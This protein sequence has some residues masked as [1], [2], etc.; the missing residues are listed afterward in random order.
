M[1]D[2]PKK[3]YLTENDI[4][5]NDNKIYNYYIALITSNDNEEIIKKK[6]Q[7]LDRFFKLQDV[8][9]ISKF[10]FKQPEE[11]IEYIE[12]TPLTVGDKIGYC[13]IAN[14][15]TFNNIDLL[16]SMSDMFLQIKE[17]V[18]EQL[19]ITNSKNL[20]IP[21]S[22]SHL[23]VLEGDFKKYRRNIMTLAFE[24]E[25][26]KNIQN[27]IMEKMNQLF[28]DEIFVNEKHVFSQYIPISSYVDASENKINAIDKFDTTMSGGINLTFDDMV[29]VRIDPFKGLDYCITFDTL[30]TL[31]DKRN[32]NNNN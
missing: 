18:L 28:T 22:I 5:I 19:N 24:D 11:E 17:M 32:D 31:D 15:G 9:N 20:N 4:D 2:L 13:P 8:E 12:S 25:K 10:A 16:L 29:L 26:V 3:V 6:K 30:N 21:I 7:T 14:L 27:L 1:I 23:K